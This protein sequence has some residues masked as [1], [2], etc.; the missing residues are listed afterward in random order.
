VNNVVLIG[1]IEPVLTLALSVWFLQERVNRWEIS[2][3][4][5]SFVGVSL[6][7]FIQPMS[8]NSQLHLGWGEILAACGA[9]AIA[10]STII[11]KK[12]LGK[13]SLGIYN[14]YRTALGTIIFFIIANV[15]YGSHHFQDAFSPFLWKWMLLYGTIIVVVGQS[16]WNFGLRSVSIAR[17]SLVSSFTPIA[18]ILAAYW[19]LGE[20]P[21]LGQYLGGTIILLGIALS[22]VGL[23]LKQSNCSRQEV[24]NK[25]GFKGV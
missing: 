13:V 23:Y 8:I 17:A 2:G 24:E 22:Q 7:I 1:R 10:I 9:I 14:I 25:L 3:A 19:I 5:A 15:I 12:W 4:I 11:G 6:T 20:T 16:F 21:T 18:G